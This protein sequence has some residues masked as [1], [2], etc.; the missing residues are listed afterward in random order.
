M[1]HGE[2]KTSGSRQSNVRRAV[3][4]VIK[5]LSQKKN[6]QFGNLFPNHSQ[7]PLTNQKVGQS[8]VQPPK[9]PAVL[10]SPSSEVSMSSEKVQLSKSPFQVYQFTTF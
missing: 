6:A 2:S 8:P 3:S 10:E 9:L 4:P 7:T 1:N 5:T